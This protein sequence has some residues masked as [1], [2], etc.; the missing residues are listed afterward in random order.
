LI[1]CRDEIVD[2]ELAGLGFH[3]PVL[4]AILFEMIITASKVFARF[5]VIRRCTFRSS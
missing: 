3:Q 1:A 2:A 5:D 4:H